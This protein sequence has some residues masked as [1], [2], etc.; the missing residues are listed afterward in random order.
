MKKCSL[1]L[2]KF[3]FYEILFSIQEGHYVQQIALSVEIL[4]Y[5]FYLIIHMAPNDV[6]LLLSGFSHFKYGKH[7][8]QVLT[9]K[10]AF[11]FLGIPQQVK[12]VLELESSFNVKK[13]LK[14]VP[15]IL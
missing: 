5:I 4:M 12:S 13:L 10:V 2:E 8:T 9:R 15:V 11:S 1:H 3:T 14:T 6:W 7:I